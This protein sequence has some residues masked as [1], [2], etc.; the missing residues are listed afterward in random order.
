M[1][2][3]DVVFQSFSKTFNGATLVAIFYE[4]NEALNNG[5][6]FYMKDI[7]RSAI[8]SQ[9]RKIVDRFQSEQYEKLDNTL[10]DNEMP[11]EEG[12][13]EDVLIDF[14]R[15]FKEEMSREEFKV[16][17]F[18]AGFKYY[19]DLKHNISEFVQQKKEKNEKSADKLANT[20]VNGII[21]QIPDIESIAD[22][23]LRSP[24][25]F[26]NFETTVMDL[27]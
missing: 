17:Q 16:L 10:P 15:N 26:D 3:E 1:R 20:L 5:S 12:I 22:D 18:S 23:K 9:A 19:E 4:C 25:I 14:E 27:L 6:I 13:F 24:L 21:E 7:Y 11:M 2:I 8:M